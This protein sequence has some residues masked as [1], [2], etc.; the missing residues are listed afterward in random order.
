MINQKPEIE[1]RY[2]QEKIIKAIRDFFYEQEFHEVVTPVLNEK[3]PLEPN[4]YPFETKWRTI[5]GTKKLFLSTSPEKNLKKMLASGMGDCFSIGHSF[6]NLESSGQL[7][8]PEFLML[9]WYRENSDY[10]VI[11]NDV[12]DLILYIQKRIKLKAMYNRL[13]DWSSYSLVDLFKEHTQLDLEKIVLSDK[14]LFEYAKMKEYQT[15]HATWNQLYDQIFVNEIEP[16]LPLYPLFL[17]D[18]PS[19]ISPL[20]KPKKNE[21]YLAERFEL[22]I[23]RTELANG[24]TENTD[25]ASVKKVFIQE[26]AMR[27][28][29]GFVSPGIDRAFLDSLKRMSRYRYAGI[30]LGIDRL[31][32]LLYSSFN[33]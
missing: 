6:R 19:R 13:N 3:I 2:L 11:M 4:I 12:K 1:V 32:R 5:K 22:Y 7:H 20:C 31:V 29:S 27:L 15:T 21:P 17:T 23:N 18:F 28:R 8:T 9:E 30:G 10:Q 14:R 33:T 24:N 26:H 16:L 25:S